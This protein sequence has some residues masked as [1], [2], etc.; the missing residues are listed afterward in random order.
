MQTLTHLQDP[1]EAACHPTKDIQLVAQ[2][3]I[4]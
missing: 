1:S 4:W 3:Y 2:Q